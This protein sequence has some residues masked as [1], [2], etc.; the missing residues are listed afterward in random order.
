MNKL[1]SN[2]TPKL[3]YGSKEINTLQTEEFNYRKIIHIK[4]IL[5][6]G[7]IFIKTLI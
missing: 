7:D 2:Q 4:E 1:G 3:K 6:I 5:V